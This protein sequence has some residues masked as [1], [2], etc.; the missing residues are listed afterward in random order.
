MR[1]VTDQLLRLV[2]IAARS[3]PGHV[4]ELHDIGSRYAQ[5]AKELVSGDAR[6]VLLDQWSEDAKHVEGLLEPAAFA[7]S[8]PPQRTADIVAGYGELWSAR[9]LAAYLRQ[10]MGT[11]RAGTW[12][13]ARRVVT[14]RHGELGPAVLWERSRRNWNSVLREGASPVVVITGFIAADDPRFRQTVETVLRE[15]A[16]GPFP[17]LYRYHNDDGVGGP[18]GAFLL[19]SFWLVEALALGG[20]VERARAALAAL[21]EHASPLGLYSE[22]I[23]PETLE[24]LGNF[25]QGFSHLGLINAVFRLEAVKQVD[26]ASAW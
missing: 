7:P 14:I 15:L 10:R 9:L 13:D 21:M 4:T 22:E 18:E 11:D 12:V 17:L 25:P 20:E 2:S 1:G 23:H 8:A 26:V 16:A 6:V 19:P 3:E 24:L 5:A